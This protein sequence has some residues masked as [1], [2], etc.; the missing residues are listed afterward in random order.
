MNNS[1]TILCRKSGEKKVTKKT[2]EKYN[3]ILNTMR[4]D[5]WYKASEFE[6][7]VDVKESRIK[8]LL[9]ELVKQ[10]KIESTGSTKGKKY[11]KIK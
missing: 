10:E 8:I 11:S 4:C 5:R 2:E 7:I 1:G 3:A 9:N 6:N